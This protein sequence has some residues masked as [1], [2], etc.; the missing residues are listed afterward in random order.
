MKEESTKKEKLTGPEKFV[1]DVVKIGDWIDKCTD[2][3]QIENIRKFYNTIISKQWYPLMS[4]NDINTSIDHLNRL[5]QL[6]YIKLGSRD[7][8]TIQQ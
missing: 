2:D 8:K 7:L 4:N 6:Q 5:V 1:A 3:I